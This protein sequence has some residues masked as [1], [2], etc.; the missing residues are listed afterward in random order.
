MS[1]VRGASGPISIGELA[2]P[3]FVHLPEP[4]T[5]FRVRAERFHALAAGHA[6]GPHLTF[7]ADLATIQERLTATLELPAAPSIEELEGAFGFGLAP[8]E[9]AHFDVNG[10]VLA[11]SDALLAALAEVAMPDA[12]RDSL[13]RL[14]SAGT[15][16]RQAALQRVLQDSAPSEALAEHA[17]LTAALQ[18]VFSGI[19]ADLEAERLQPVADGTSCPV[20]G[21]PPLGSLVVGGKGLHGTRFCSCGLC[22]TLWND[23]RLKCTLCGSTEGI[24]YH[25]IDGDAGTITAESCESC[26]RY[27]KLLNQLKDPALEP[28]A[29]D[30]ASFGLDLLMR[31]AG[32]SRGVV[33]PFLFGQ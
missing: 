30:I 18:I 33:N 23:V 5:L 29:D 9:R 7:L 24:A 26:H 22:G 11:A 6:L 13:T 27:V 28:L 20:C 14:T 1:G 19:A 12:A 3:S 16:A 4:G 8:V 15:E 32:F 17:L 2:E 31:K 21:S 25:G 10:S